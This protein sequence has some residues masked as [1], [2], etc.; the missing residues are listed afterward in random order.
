[1]CVQTFGESYVVF[2]SLNCCCCCY[3]LDNYDMYSQRPPV[4]KRN[5]PGTVCL[6]S[7]QNNDI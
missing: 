2:T 3:C 1:M 4:Q 5:V 7:N 6:H